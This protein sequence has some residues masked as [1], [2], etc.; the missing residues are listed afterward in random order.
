[1]NER[2]EL[3]MKQNHDR[4]VKVCHNF[5]EYEFMILNGKEA[6]QTYINSCA[7]HY[8]FLKRDAIKWICYLIYRHK[9]LSKGLSHDSYFSIFNKC[10]LL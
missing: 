1:M 2:N 10:I 9:M 5:V 4:R 7:M 8:I 3:Q 6:T